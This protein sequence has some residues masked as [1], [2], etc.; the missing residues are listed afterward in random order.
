MKNNF[1]D[2][3]LVVVYYNNV[4]YLCNCN[5]LTNQQQLMKFQ[6]NDGGR[7]KYFK[8]RGGDC[9]TRSIAI[10]TGMDYKEVYDRIAHGN[11]TQRKSK[12]QKKKRGKTALKGI[13]VKRK[14]FKDLMHEWGFEWVPTMTIGSGCKVHLKADELPDGKIIC[15]VSKHYVAVINGVIHDL[16]DCSRDGTRCVYGYWIYKD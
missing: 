4:A 13:N 5:Q 11:A 10:V 1:A 6:L 2:F 16:Y 3:R 7:S 15:S 9:V 12:Y 14:W 8:G